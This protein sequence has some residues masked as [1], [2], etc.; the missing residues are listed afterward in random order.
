[1][2]KTK[3]PL[4]SL[5]AGGQ[6]GKSQVYASW[7]GVP[8]VRQHV[9]PANPRT[10]EQVLTRGTFS[11]LVQL[12]KL[13]GALSQAPW[14]ANAKGKPFTNRNKL[15][16]ENLPGLRGSAD[17]TPW[18]GSP[19]ALGG[20]PLSNL[21]AVGGAASGEID[22]TLT[23]PAEPTDWTI[24]SLTVQA[25]R[26]RSPETVPSELVAEAEELAPVVDGNNVIT[27][28]GLTAGADYVVSGWI[29]WTR[30]DGKTAYG[31][32][33]TTGIVVATA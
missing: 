29:V 7:R 8:Y 2:A 5:R 14:T 27:L 26:D 31:G 23:T 13:L 12:W 33:L 10:T 11:G 28:T 18:I 25:L 1:M 6:I 3:S 20:F 4:L 21:S 17:M 16:N 32:S 15:I 24:A 9:V 22:A 19:G 30:P